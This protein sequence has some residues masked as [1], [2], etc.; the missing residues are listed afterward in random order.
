M[1]HAYEM[2][3][4]QQ[5]CMLGDFPADNVPPV[6]ADEGRRARLLLNPQTPEGLQEASAAVLV[7]PRPLRGG[8]L[9]LPC[10]APE[11]EV[12]HQERGHNSF[13]EGAS[14]GFQSFREI[15]F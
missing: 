8:P 15:L 4:S 3:T 13:R 5:K 12:L 14:A 9:E 6:M 11:V 7:P 1:R 10:Q 2:I